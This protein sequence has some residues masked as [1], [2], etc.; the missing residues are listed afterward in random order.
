MRLAH[1]T[2]PRILRPGNAAASP[3]PRTRKSGGSS[4]V[5]V[6]L[7]LPSRSPR[8]AEP[9]WSKWSA[10]RTNDLGQAGSVW[11]PSMHAGWR[12]A[13]RGGALLLNV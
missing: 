11:L 9:A 3:R 2:C 13:R 1:T 6:G 12:P 10:Q 4:P 5:V 8:G 7:A